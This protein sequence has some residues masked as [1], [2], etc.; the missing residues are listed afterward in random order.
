MHLIRITND[1]TRASEE[2]SFDSHKLATI[3]KEY[4]LAFGNWNNCSRWVDEHKVTIEERPYI[5]DE[6]TELRGGEI[7]RLYR[8]TEGFKIEIEEVTG[9]SQALDE[10]WQNFRLLRN[11]ALS[12]TDWSQLA[13]VTMSQ[14]VRKQYRNYRQYLRD[15]PT[16]H[17]DSTVFL[18]KIYTFDEFLNGKR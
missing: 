1:K 7:V 14:E 15:L 11:E 10:V 4:H 17:S 6:M 9:P 3:Y 2:L 13:D 16:L 18:A 8:I 12:R 5:C